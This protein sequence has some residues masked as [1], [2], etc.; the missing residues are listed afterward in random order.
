MPEKTF[1][2]RPIPTVAE[3]IA[4][5]A[6]SNDIGEITAI[7]AAAEKRSDRIKDISRARA[8]S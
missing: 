8:K 2:P 3:I 1:T 4:F 7:S 5:I 6:S